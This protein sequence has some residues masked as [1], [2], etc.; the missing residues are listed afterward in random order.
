MPAAAAAIACQHLAHSSSPATGSTEKQNE[1]Q[2]NLSDT[3]APE[4]AFDTMLQPWPASIWHTVAALQQAVQKSTARG[5]T[6]E[7]Q[8]HS[9]SHSAAAMACQHLAHSSSSAASIVPVQ[10]HSV[11]ETLNS[12]GC[13]CTELRLQ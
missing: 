4:T 3:V 6:I 9:Y 12:D 1:W 5:S 10:I 13:I 8:W 7:L 2:Y 11:K